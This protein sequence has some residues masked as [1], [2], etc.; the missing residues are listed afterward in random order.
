MP[1]EQEWFS[2]KEAASKLRVTAETV[3]RLIRSHSLRARKFG[4]VWRV[5]ACDLEL[6]EG[7]QK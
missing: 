2:P 7:S 6:E 1:I 3:R 5:R 4:R